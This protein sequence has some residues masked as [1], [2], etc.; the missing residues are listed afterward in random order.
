MGALGRLRSL[1]LALQT[2]LAQGHKRLLRCSLFLLPFPWLI[3]PDSIRL[4]P[5]LEFSPTYGFVC[6]TPRAK[7]GGHGTCCAQCSQW[8]GCKAGLYF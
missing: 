6:S 4:P 2:S 7:H 8:L 5:P 3:A 1:S